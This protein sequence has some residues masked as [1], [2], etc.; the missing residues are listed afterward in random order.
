MLIVTIASTG[1]TQHILVVLKTLDIKN[2]VVYTEW[3]TTDSWF[4]VARPIPSLT[5]LER[6]LEL[7]H[8]VLILSS[9]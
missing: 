6:L 4:G 7:V 3:R 9:I 5:L 2:V 8:L 1:N